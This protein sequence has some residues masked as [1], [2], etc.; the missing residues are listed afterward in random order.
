MAV[1]DSWAQYIADILQKES[2]LSASMVKH[3]GE[4]GS[5]REALIKGV[6][7][8]IIPEI[9][10]I[11]SGEI[12]DHRGNHSRQMDIVIARKDFP[13]LNL[14]SWSRIY[15]V[16]AVLATIEV[17]SK[18]DKNNLLS[19][20]ENCASVAELLP[21]VVKG[22][23]DELAE[24][25]GLSKIAPGSYRHDN[26]LETARFDLLGRP[27][28]YILGFKGYK[29]NPKELAGAIS[30]WSK[31]R[32][33]NNKR[34]AMR[35]HPAVIAAEGC[36]TWRN[37]PP[38]IVDD[39]IITRV[40]V[41]KNPLRLLVLHL[42]FTLNAKI[43]SMPDSYGLMPNLGAYLRQMEPF[44]TTLAVGEAVNLNIQ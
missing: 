7:N 28:S 4:L 12:V 42:L 36:F 24:K 27:V 31:Y 17:K 38:Y 6:L 3:G 25:K 23:L 43:P 37:A 11:G 15:L 29:S 32:Q 16:E 33:E 20:L 13:S 21:N 22:K 5:A 41:D 14:P 30:E 19:A 39:N 9:Y 8:R 34:I 10:E 26:P 35:H 44:K 18:L 40:G 1:F 2:E